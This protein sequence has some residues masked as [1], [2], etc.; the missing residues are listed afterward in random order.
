VTRASGRALA[1]ALVVWA[2]GSTPAIGQVTTL[3]PAT[4][5]PTTQPPVTEPPVTEPP[6]TP[7]PAPTT[8][9]PR[10]S[11]TR[12]TTTVPATTTTVK[13]LPPPSVAPQDPT[14]APVGTTQSDHISSVFVWMSILG[15]VFFVGMLVSQWFLT[16]PGRRGW[17]L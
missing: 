6:T 1:L 9:R 16:R 12:S 13:L 14:A 2:A 5:P 7:V 17:T 3:P 4:Q 10:S 15:F 11:T 8:T